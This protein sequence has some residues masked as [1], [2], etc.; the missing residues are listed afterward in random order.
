MASFIGL[1]YFLLYMF[2]LLV[3]NT[4][5]AGFILQVAEVSGVCETG[6]VYQLG[7]T[8]TNKG[9]K[10]RY[11]FSLLCNLCWLCYLLRQC[12]IKNGMLTDMALKKGFSDSSSFQI[13]TLLTVSSVNGK[14]HVPSK[15]SR[16]QQWMT[17]TRSWRT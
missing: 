5:N 9:L 10:L 14:K 17:L 8:R 15:L 2:L 11:M 16:Y 6:K 4:G 7:T 13:K 1:A 3:P 12:Q